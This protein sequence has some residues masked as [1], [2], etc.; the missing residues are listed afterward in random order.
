MQAT[1]IAGLL[2][3]KVDNAAI[4]GLILSDFVNVIP[5]ISSL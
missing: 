5:N 1:I 2:L 4:T 3:L